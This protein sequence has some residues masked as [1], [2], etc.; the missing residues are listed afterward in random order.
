MAEIGTNGVD[1]KDFFDFFHAMLR[2]DASTEEVDRSERALRWGCANAPLLDKI[3]RK[4]E[5]DLLALLRRYWTNHHQAPSREVIGELAAKVEKPEPLRE[6]LKSYDSFVADDQLHLYDELDLPEVVKKRQNDW[7]CDRLTQVLSTARQIV[8]GPVPQDGRNKDLPPLH[9][10][11]DAVNYILGAIQKGIFVESAPPRGGSIA[12]KAMEIVSV[13]EQIEKDALTGNLLMRTGLAAIDDVIYGIKRKE[14]TTIIGYAGQ[15]KSTVCRTVA[16]NI[17]KLGFRILYIPL[18]TTFDEELAFFSLIHSHAGLGNQQQLSKS[19][20]DN[21][22]L[23]PEEKQ[24]LRDVLAPRFQQEIG[25][26]LIIREPQSGRRTW[27]DI[28]AE[29]ELEHR[30][31]PLDA[32]LIDYVGLLDPP[33]GERDPVA[34]MNRTFKQIKQTALNFDNKLGL[35]VITPVQGSRDGYKQAKA[36]EGVWEAHGIFMYSEAE[37]SSDTCIYVFSDET[38]V[39]MNALKMGT[40][41]CRRSKYVAAHIVPVDPHCGYVG[42]EGNA[43]VEDIQMQQPNSQD[44][45]RDSDLQ[46]TTWRV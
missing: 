24:Y 2:H 20:F 40:C 14:L 19:A 29:I 17:A 3:T 42:N 13:Y 6:L 32:V 39:S 36:N 1:E 38:L 9:G 12:D 41:K 44:D 10:T 46:I 28:R 31:H 7:D 37:K 26:H 27:A 25:D 43:R 8:A 16:Y 30:I 34:A 23:K 4:V 18:E 21:G 15:R 22:L 11:Q 45:D 33:E 5:R 35:A